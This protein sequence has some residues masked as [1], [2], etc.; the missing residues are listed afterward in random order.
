MKKRAAHIVIVGGS[1]GSYP[2]IMDLLRVLP[3]H[4]SSALIIVT[5]RNPK[6]STK[7]EEMLSERFNREIIQAT[8]KAPIEEGGIYFATPGYHLLIEP[9]QRFSLDISERIQYARPA[10]DVLFETAGEVYRENCTA[11]LLSG[12]NKDGSDGMS[13][14]RLAGS[15]TI[16]QCPND[17]P[18]PTMP[19]HAIEANQGI[20]IYTNRQIL[21]YFRNLI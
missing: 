1:A 10:I 9:D 6:F 21:S 2:L 11:F 12:A 20:A 16:V 7:F 13:R 18:I 14:L 5:H 15:T 8:D 19:L 17:A 3:A 4:F